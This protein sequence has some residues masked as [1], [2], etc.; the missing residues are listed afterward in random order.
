MGFY[1]WVCT[2]D[3]SAH[4]GWKE[5]QT[6]GVGLTGGCAPPNVGPG[7]E[8]RSSAAAVC[9]LNTA[10]SLRCH[11]SHWEKAFSSARVGWFGWLTA[12]KN[13]AV[14][15]KECSWPGVCPD[16]DDVG[17]KLFVKSP[18][19]LPFWSNQCHWLIS[20]SS[21]SNPSNPLVFMFFSFSTHSPLLSNELKTS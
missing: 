10:S 11:H 12:G 4:L 3:C 20:G 8:V 19:D 18:N 14:T 5:C 9:T 1:A 21:P 6:P 13:T 2:D 15:M 16:N 7:D 17:N